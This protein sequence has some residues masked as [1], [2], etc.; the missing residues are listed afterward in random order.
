MVDK[1]SNYKGQK[2]HRTAGLRSQ[3]QPLRTVPISLA[4]HV[5]QDS[6][7]LPISAVSSENDR[8][9][10]EAWLKLVDWTGKIVSPNIHETERIELNINPS[11]LHKQ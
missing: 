2:P 8:V 3:V 9:T 6:K 7:P 4:R 10:L 1:S 11:G 5:K